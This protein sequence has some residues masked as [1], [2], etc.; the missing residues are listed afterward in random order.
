MKSTVAAI[1]IGLCLSACSSIGNRSAT[2][3][4]AA[5]PLS[6]DEKHRLYTAALFASES[7]LE[8]ESF[9]EVCRTIG[10]FDAGGN[11][12]DHYLPFV[13]AHVD[14]AMK[15]ETQQFKL[16]IKTKEMARDYVIKHCALCRSNERPITAKQG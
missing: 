4:D 14:W 6:E 12:N 15:V 7:P 9:R 5:S 2:K 13:S 10:I 1:L 11:P 3:I 16:E 8:S